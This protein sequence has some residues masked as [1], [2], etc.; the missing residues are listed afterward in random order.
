METFIDATKNI[1]KD[2]L[3]TKHVCKYTSLFKKEQ[4]SFRRTKTQKILS[5]QTLTKR[6]NSHT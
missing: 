6:G 4:K 1:I 5:Q 3:K 2:E